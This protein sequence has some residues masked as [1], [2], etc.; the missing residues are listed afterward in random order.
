MRGALQTRLRANK[1]A[2]ANVELLRATRVAQ[3]ATKAGGKQLGWTKGC[4][5]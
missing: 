4:L 5:Q 2:G 1:H 3:N